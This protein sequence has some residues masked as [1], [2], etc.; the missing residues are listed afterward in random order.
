MK[1][2]H[3]LFTISVLGFAGFCF[4]AGINTS[5]RAQVIIVQGPALPFKDLAGIEPS[6]VELIDAGT[7]LLVVNDKKPDLLVVD[8]EKREIKANL[9]IQGFWDWEAMAKD[10]ENNYYLIGS[11]SHLI[12]FRLNE[13]EKDPAK[14]KIESEP[15]L[16]DI[17]KSFDSIKQVLKDQT[18]EIEGLAVLESG[19]TKELIVGI[20]TNSGTVHIYRVAL[21]GELSL[22][23]FFHFDVKKTQDVNWHLS[24]IEYVPDWK[25]FLIVLSTEN[26]AT[27]EFYGN[28]LWFVSDKKLE[29]LQQG[30]T[31]YIG[32]VTPRKVEVFEEKMKAEG[33]VVVCSNKAKLKVVIVFDNDYSRK[34][35]AAALAFVDLSKPIE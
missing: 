21:T 7:Y 12:R 26:K 22:K 33:L 4:F 3:S 16:L 25:G 19:G 29:G 35:Q 24:S 32:K 34:K 17:K 18:I 11:Q 1:R 10:S 15:V 14:I 30:S 13:K 27:N 6:A 8:A 28:M 20:R 9:L 5:I 31:G 2:I 23:P